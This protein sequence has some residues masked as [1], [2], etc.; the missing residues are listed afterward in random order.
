MKKI[1]LPIL[2]LFIGLQFT[3]AQVVTSDPTFPLA[4]DPV[5]VYFYAN[6]GNGGLQ[7]YTGDVYAH[8]GVI[9]ENSTSGTDWKYVKTDWGENTAA[10][11]LTRITEDYYSIHISP[12]IRAFYGVPA[13]E[14]ILQLAFV[15]RDEAG[16]ATGKDIGGSDIFIDLFVGQMQVS[17]IS[18]SEN[19]I[20]SAATE[21]DFSAASSEEAEIKLYLNETLIKTETNVA[22]SHSFNIDTPGDYWIKVFAT[23]AETTVADSVFVHFLGT[24][25]N[26]SLPEGS[27]DGINYIDDASARLVLFAPGKE[28]VFVLGEFNDWIPNNESRMKKD[29]DRFWLPIADLAP[30]TEYA[31]QYLVD[32]ELY[33]ADPY[34]EKVLDPSNDK[35]ISTETYP[36]LKPY[37]T[38]FGQGIVSVLQTAQTPYEWQS[39]SFT[40]PENEDLIIYE[41]L[42][43]D[44]IAA[45]D[46]KTLIDTLGYFSTLGINAI[47]LMPFNEFEGNESWGYNPSFYFAPDK[48]YGPGEDLKAFIDACHAR[49]IAVIMDMVLNHS[50]DQSPLA[51]LYFDAA[52]SR[53]AADNP[54]YNVDAPHE[55]SWGNDFDHESDATKYFMDRVNTYWLEEYKLDGYRFDFTK[56]F[57]NKAGSGWGY[58]ASRIAILKRMADVIWSANP[59]AYVI[60]EH[61]SDNV[62]QKELGN[63]GMMVWDKANP[64]FNEATMGWHEGG[65]SNLSRISYQSWGWDVPHIVSFMESHDE[66]RLMVKNLL[67]GNSSG[68]YNIKNL[69]TALARMEIAAAFFFTVPGPKMIWQFGELGYDYSIDFNGRVGNKPIKWDYYDEDARQRLYQVYSALIHLR[70]AEP[71]FTTEDYSLSVAAEA[72]RIELNHLD[73]DVRIIGNF[74][75][76]PLEIDP[77]FSETG[78]WYE[79]FSG[80]SLDVTNVNEEISLLAGQYRIYT[81]KQLETPE[82]IDGVYND[83]SIDSRTMLYPIPAAETLNIETESAASKVSIFDLNGRM[84]SQSSAMGTRQSIDVS[85]LTGGVYFMQIE[86]EDQHTEFQKFIKK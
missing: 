19:L 56:G 23:S 67:Y 16:S 81:T 28:H 65:K 72:K 18:P 63:Y 85:G 13:Q 64:E 52:N 32:G 9:T 7:D 4:S 26:E 76:A 43:R 17:V 51:Q 12:S 46:W 22:I 58:D 59:D 48:Y 42:L 50:Y 78:M 45:H 82:I 55:Y 41:L 80:E 30:G 57:T 35:W 21:I 39:S 25:V 5:T 24:Q 49:G 83:H 14:E 68:T 8:M 44:F 70:T 62:E 33:I 10:T 40:A 79:F 38:D 34:A 75:V 37:P 61:W 20:L 54:W 27:L 11:K 1:A 47:E 86:L 15:F 84:I 53:P 3:A 31:Y 6:E 29:N 74:D 77:N 71:A 60:L 36:D 73:M 69:P 2:L 66:E